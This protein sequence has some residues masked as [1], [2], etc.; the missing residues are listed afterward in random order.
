MACISTCL[1]FCRVSH[2]PSLM[3]HFAVNSAKNFWSADREASASSLSSWAWAPSWSVFASCW[4]FCS[5]E[6]CPASI[7]SSF[8]TF[9]SAKAAELKVAK[10]DEIEA[11]QTSLEQKFVQLQFHLPSPPSIP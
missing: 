1:A 10:E 5:K 7:S 3:A 9:N 2:S 8:A 4:D 11:G 6:V